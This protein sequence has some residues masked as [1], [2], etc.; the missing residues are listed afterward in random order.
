M[1]L[2][3]LVT[4]GAGFIG[5]NFIRRI[6]NQRP[7]YRITN[8]DCLTYSG[9]LN[10]LSDVDASERYQFVRGNIC[11]ADLVSEL[12]ASAD[13]VVHFAAES[14]VDR[15]I[16]NATPF[17]DSNVRGTQVLLDAARRLGNRRFVHISTDEVYGSLPLDHPELL[18]TED[19]PLAPNSPYAASKAAADLMVRAYHQTYGVDTVTTRCSNNLGPYQFPEKL[20]PC[21]VTRLAQGKQV[22]V[23]GDG[24]NVRDWLHVDD[25]CEAV[26]Q[27]LEKGTSG[28]VYNIGGNNERSNLELTHELLRIMNLDA[29]SID[30][31]PD[32]LGHDR[33][34]AVCCQKISQELGWEPAYSSWPQ[35]LERT[36]E[37]YLQNTQW[38]KSIEDGS[39]QLASTA[40]SP[41]AA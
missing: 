17:V 18:F 37:W 41:P 35:A 36:V 22:P 28:E 21:F 20:I 25:H 1:S 39:Y 24:K 31:V 13:V 8:L 3:L 16:D 6:I 34:Y 26:L 5:S 30:F 14:H 7:A 15:S 33:R 11:D 9:N 27:V 12:V 10:N 2:N 32:R 38:W 19:S 29:R 23:Y 40:P 4:G